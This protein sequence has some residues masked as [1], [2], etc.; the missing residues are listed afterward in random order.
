MIDESREW[1]LRWFVYGHLPEGKLRDTS[2]M[3]SQLAESIYAKVP[4][5][6]ERSVSLRKLLEAKDCAV[7]AVLEP[8]MIEKEVER[9]RKRD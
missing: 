3:F 7:R 8:P 5:C 1:T 6:P 9:L 4:A 2:R